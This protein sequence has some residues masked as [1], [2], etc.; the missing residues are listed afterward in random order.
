MMVM[1]GM[2]MAFVAVNVVTMMMVMAVG[3]MILVMV[4]MALVAMSGLVLVVVLMAFV[5]VG[6]LVLMVVFMAFVAVG[7]LV[8]AVVFMAFVAVDMAVKPVSGSGF[9]GFM[10]MGVGVSMIMNVFALLFFPENSHI[11]MCSRDPAFYGRFRFH[12]HAR[13]TQSV[14][15]SKKFFLL[16]RTQ[17]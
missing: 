3:I 14:H 1:V 16:F 15:F 12:L 2:T 8:P 17:F 10:G 13:Q 4:G 6:G 9:T 11:H 5:A 7:A